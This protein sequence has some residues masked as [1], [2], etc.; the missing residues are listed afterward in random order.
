VGIL[1]DHGADPLKITQVGR[2][3][4]HHAAEAA[5]IEV[6]E[7]LLR[8]GCNERGV[9]INLHDY[10]GETPLHIAT[11]RSADLVKVLL[12]HGAQIGQR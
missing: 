10:W 5:N 12:E 3:I 6:L 7:Y 11:T 4:F 2:N 9:D 8:K 1:L